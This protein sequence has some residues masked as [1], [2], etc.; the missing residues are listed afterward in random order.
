MRSLHVITSDARR[1]AETFAMELT[2]ALDASGGQEVRT[3]ALTRS[4]DPMGLD[5]PVLGPA[6]RSPRTLVAL[7]RAAGGADVV[8]AHGSSTLEACTVAL[9]GTDVPYVYRSIGD[10]GYWVAAGFRRRGVGML[11][12]RAARVVALWPA[13]ADQI[14]SM[15]DVPRHRIDVIPNAVDEDRFVIATP[16]ERASLRAALDVPSDAAC[17]AF[18]GALAREKRVAVAIDATAAMDRATL[19]IAGAGPL[20]AELRRY[21]DQV[22]P[23][24]VRFLGQVKDTRPVYA[25]ADLL[26]LPS[27]SEGLPAVLVEAG[28]VGTPT[29]GTAVGAIPSTIEDGA[30]GYLSGPPD[31][32]RFVARVLDALP[33]AREVGA[34]A[35]VAFRGRHA[36]DQVAQSWV[37]TLEEAR[38]A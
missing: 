22:A 37:R 1:G 15:H 17:F 2:A 20:E 29:V 38:R 32:D 27:A 33:T 16:E 34:R 4:D 24:R 8:V 18:V 7:R 36:M 9:A 31:R 28:L 13:A 26:L 30:T 25:A 23:Q 5:V 3:V 35:A 11:L 6:R 14:A 19:L 10:P 12:R 21:A